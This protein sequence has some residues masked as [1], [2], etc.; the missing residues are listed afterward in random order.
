M[1]EGQATSGERA[2]A[3]LGYSEAT[4]ELDAIVA[5]F[6]QGD[7]DVDQ[8]VG[9]LERASA[10]VEE[11]DRRLRRTRTQVE[12]LV[13]RLEAAARSDD[14]S[15]VAKEPVDEEVPPGLF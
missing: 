1:S 11:L 3:D 15:D 9:K 10:I 8:L 6:E 5:F 12:E 7:L 4:A 14:E 2:P 13:P